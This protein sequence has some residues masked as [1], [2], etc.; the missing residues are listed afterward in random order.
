MVVDDV[1]SAKDRKILGVLWKVVLK[2]MRFSESQ[3]H[4]VAKSYLGENYRPDDIDKF[5]DKLVNKK[6]LRKIRGRPPR[7]VV[8][9][10]LVQ[11]LRNILKVFWSVAS[12]GSLFTR[13]DIHK[14]AVIYLKDEYTPLY[15]DEF[16]NLLIREGYL[17][18]YPGQRGQ[19]PRYLVTDKLMQLLIE[20]LDQSTLEDFLKGRSTAESLDE[21]QDQ[22]LKIEDLTVPQFYLYLQNYGI[23][24][25][26][27]IEKVVIEYDIGSRNPKKLLREM[28]LDC[29]REHNKLYEEYQ[30]EISKKEKDLRMRGMTRLRTIIKKVFGDYLQIPVGSSPRRGYLIEVPEGSRPGKIEIID[31]ETVESLLEKRILDDRIIVDYEPSDGDVFDGVDSSVH[32]VKPLLGY[33]VPEFNLFTVVSVSMSPGEDKPNVTVRPEPDEI[34]TE[35]LSTLERNGFLISGSDLLRFD[36]Y[37]INRIK[38]ATMQRLQYRTSKETLKGIR[39][40]GVPI[41]DALYLDG[42]IWPTEH[43]FSDFLAEHRRYVIDALNDFVEMAQAL[44]EDGPMVI[45]IV[46]RG[47]LGFLWYLI[48]WFAYKNKLIDF[49][50]FVLEPKLYESL[51]NR[52][53]VMALRMLI[54][55]YKA[56]DRYGRLFAV[57]RKFYAM[58]PEIIPIFLKVASEE[59]KKIHDVEEDLGFWRKVVEEI[60]I[61]R[62]H[63]CRECIEVFEEILEGKIDPT[64][65]SENWRRL[66]LPAVERL[67]SSDKERILKEVKSTKSYRRKYEILK[68]VLCGKDILDDEDKRLIGLLPQAYALGDVVSTYYLPPIEYKEEF[69]NLFSSAHGIGF[70][71][72]RI[73]DFALPRIDIL[74]PMFEWKLEGRD[75]RECTRKYVDRILFKPESWEEVGMRFYVWYDTSE[76]VQWNLIVTAPVKM[77]HIYSKETL[78]REVAPKYAAVITTVIARL[79]EELEREQG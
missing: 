67:S 30:R 48:L 20:K 28:L 46:K 54:Y 72:G 8:T 58:D 29:V 75:P 41:P 40:E 60:I 73:P 17:Y 61:S 16:L 19:Q 53:G 51:E 9:D 56:T 62:K 69:L 14:E 77:A 59:G 24:V 78:K 25:A 33:P 38:E 27:L 2:T 37:Y 44:R 23:N 68:K 63:S 26:E 43:K 7:Y 64:Q 6:Y 74:L 12:N 57:R 13:D 39:D 35:K 36:D 66:I 10:K 11:L 65:L 18:V 45:G 52:D 3:I 49:N 79:R 31:I 47:H 70:E 50:K 5:L 4:K 42:R 15:I 71:P 32:G 22:I 76:G 34:A 1:F 55:H 21:V